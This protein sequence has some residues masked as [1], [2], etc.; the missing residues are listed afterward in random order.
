MENLQEI[1]KKC[2]RLPADHT[3][4]EMHDCYGITYLINFIKKYDNS[5]KKSVIMAYAIQYEMK[6]QYNKFIKS[7]F[8]FFKDFQMDKKLP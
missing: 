2:N 5:E 3:V 4:F 7:N 1:C 6:R 8:S